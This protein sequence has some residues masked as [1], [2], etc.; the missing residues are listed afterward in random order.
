MPPHY[1]PFLSDADRRALLALA[2][3]A[4]LQAVLSNTVPDSP[5]LAHSAE[6][7]GAF[8]TLRFGGQLRGCV[9]RVD[10]A[11]SLAE[12]VAQSAITAAMSDPRFKPVSAAELSA[13]QIE[14][15]VL[16]QPW[17]IGPG[18]FEPGTHG[19]IVIQGTGRGLLLPQVASERSW[20]R[21]EFLEAA[22]RKAGLRAGGWR[23]PETRF[24]AFTAEVFSESGLFPVVKKQAVDVTPNLPAT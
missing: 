19:I 8:V 21:D 17:E 10:S 7:G 1:S 15:S 6:V 22:C 16:S 3:C 9:G 2:R 18:E 23:N 12:I 5:P 24:F 14:I 13:L 4:I 11:D 20:S